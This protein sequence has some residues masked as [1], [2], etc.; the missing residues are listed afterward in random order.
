MAGDRISSRRSVLVPLCAR[1][2]RSPTSVRPTPSN[3]RCWPQDRLL[4]RSGRWG[5]QWH[6]HGQL[7]R[8]IGHRGEMKPKT[9]HR[10]LRKCCTQALPAATLRSDLIKSAKSWL[11]QPSNSLARCPQRF[12][13]TPSSPLAL[14]PASIRLTPKALVT[15]LS[16]PA[17]QTVLKPRVSNKRGGVPH[18]A[19]PMATIP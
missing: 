1:V 11:S 15:F 4:I 3:A 2:P 18:G 6:L 13:T 14:L 7:A 19:P 10:R 12:R 16:S 9:K 5:C 17:A 8:T